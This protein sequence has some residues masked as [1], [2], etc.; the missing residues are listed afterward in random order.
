[1]AMLVIFF[2]F[3]SWNRLKLIHD[4]C[5]VKTRIIYIVVYSFRLKRNAASSREPLFLV[6][7]VYFVYLNRDRGN[8][9]N[10]DE[11]SIAS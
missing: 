2:F 6:E 7:D 9:L 11:I 8:L 10:I 1:M 5:R 4:C 3:F